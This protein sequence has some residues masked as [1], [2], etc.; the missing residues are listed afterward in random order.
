MNIYNLYDP[1]PQTAASVMYNSPGQT[2]IV[3]GSPGYSQTIQTTHTVPGQ[4]GPF[5]IVPVSAIPAPR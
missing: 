3:L 1:I 4:P 2:V 5:H